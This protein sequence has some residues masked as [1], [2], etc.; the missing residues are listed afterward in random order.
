MIEKITLDCLTLDS[1]SILKQEFD[2]NGNQ[3]GY[4]TRRAYMNSDQSRE[5]LQQELPEDK[6]NELLEV[7]GDTPTVEDYVEPTISLEEQKTGLIAS[8]SNQ[9]NNVITKGFDTTLSD[10]NIYHFSLTIKDQ[11]M[12]QAL[13]LKVKSGET[14]LPYHADGESCRYFT[15][16]EISL[17]YS[18]MEQL[19][20]YNTTYFNSLRD[21]I[22]SV[23]TE[24]E[25]S[26]I[27][28]GIE[29]PEEYQSEVLKSLLEVSYEK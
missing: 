6:Y 23:T 15:A 13:M 27:K 20:T 11:L 17:L 9:C 21:Y 2:K 22:N 29:I 4:N 12:I 16:D 26:K 5:E 8:M 10:G 14:V 24:K 3:V 7:W 28:Y 18:N 19:I 1:V 25:L